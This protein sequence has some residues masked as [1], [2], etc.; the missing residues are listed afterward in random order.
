MRCENCCLDVFDLCELQ[1]SGF[2]CRHHLIHIVH[3]NVTLS[4]LINI[5]N[6]H[7]AINLVY[8]A[9]YWGYNFY[10][11][12]VDYTIHCISYIYVYK[13]CVYILAFMYLIQ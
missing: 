7:T 6:K 2:I 5:K 9:V 8:I 4:K 10:K 11:C 13:V 12:L 3:E 1:Q